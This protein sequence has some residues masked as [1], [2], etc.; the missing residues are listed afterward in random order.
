MRRAR[1]EKRY[2]SRVLEVKKMMDEAEKKDVQENLA[3]SRDT[4]STAE[5]E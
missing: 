4:T 3:Q 2:S 5:K 1:F